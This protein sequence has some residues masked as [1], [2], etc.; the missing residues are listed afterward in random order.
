MAQGSD[1]DVT[2]V[3]PWYPSAQLPFRGSFVQAMVEAVAPT[4]RRLSV[5]H[6]D[7]WVSRMTPR[8]D[9]EVTAAAHALSGAARQVRPGPG[10]AEVV[11]L[12]VPIPAGTGYADN[13]RRH[14]AMLRAVLGGTPL[15]GEVV[16]AHV[17][18]PSGWAAL[19]NLRP[20]ARLFVTEHASFLPLILAD[21]DARAR[22]GEVLA[23]CTALFAVGDGVLDLLAG[24]FPRHADRIRLMPNPV[25]F[26]AGRQ[27]PVRSLERW[28]Y[29]GSLKVEKGVDLLLEAFA[30]CWAEDAAL[31]LTLVGEGPLDGPL[32]AR[33]AALG[34]ADAVVLTG[35]VTPPEALRLMREHDLLVHN[36]RSE[37]FGMVVVEA[38]AAGLPVLVTRCGGPE[39][40]LAGIEYAAGG[41]VEVDDDPATFAAGYR[42]LRARF[43]EG[44]DL[45]YAREALAARYGYPA[46]AAA[47]HEA[48]FGSTPV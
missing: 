11:H 37:T 33:A 5:Y 16:H 22:Y 30:Q 34:V 31:R 17:G 21:A 40:T 41:L 13:A 43:P 8:Q 15:A 12:P 9:A 24:T 35:A 7:D 14:A 27:T 28:L 38:L 42:R 39:R 32:R 44:L 19:H 1:A 46:V 47:H 25:S 6:C 20:G 26:A 36:S 48:W 23:R 45:A 10:G 4:V 29:V 2:V 3:T 18:L